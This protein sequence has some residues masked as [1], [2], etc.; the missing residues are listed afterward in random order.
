MSTDVSIRTLNGTARFRQQSVWCLCCYTVKR[1]QFMAWRNE[2]EVSERALHQQLADSQRRAVELCLTQPVSI[3]TGGPGVGKTT[4]LRVI[5]DIYHR[6]Q[7]DNEILL[8]A[9]TGKSQQT[10]E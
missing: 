3:I 1:P 6:T 8:V 4:T 5:L 7:P 2:I 9:P 10:H